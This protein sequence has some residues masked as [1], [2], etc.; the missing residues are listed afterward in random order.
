MLETALSIFLIGMISVFTVLGIVI[1]CARGVIWITNKWTPSPSEEMATSRTIQQMDDIG[2]PSAH[3]KVI[4]KLILDI[5]NGHGQVG[6][7]ERI[8]S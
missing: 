1:L 5:T 8:V 7:I 2:I 3:R 4:E 6:H